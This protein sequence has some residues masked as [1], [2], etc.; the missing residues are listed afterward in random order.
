MS[1][2]QNPVIET[3]AADWR[4]FETTHRIRTYKV[5][6]DSLET[7]W[8]D[9]RISNYHFL[10]LRDNCPCSQ[11]VHPRTR[12]QLFEVL[13]APANLSAQRISLDKEGKLIVG[14]S[15]G[16]NSQYEAGW[17]RSHAYDPASRSERAERLRSVEPWGSELVIPS[18]DYSEVVSSDSVLLDW[19]LAARDVGL[20]MLTGVPSANEAVET[21]AKRISFMRET[22][23]GSIFEVKTKAETTDSNAYTSLELPAHTDM[24]TRELQPGLQF[25]HC[26]INDAAGGESTFVDGFAIAAALQAEAPED[27]RVLCEHPID[28]WNKAPQSDYRSHAPIIGLDARGELSEIRLTN[29]LRAPINLPSSEMGAFY[30]AY[31]H[32]S[33]LTRDS[34]FLVSHRLEAGQMWCFDNRRIMHGR[35][36]FDPTSGQ[37]F[38]R[39]GYMD[40][41][42][43]LSRIRVLERSH[44]RSTPMAAS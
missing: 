3:F 24:S 30:R 22:N 18:F 6:S 8:D 12:E 1:E 20:T 19:L 33:A 43:L 42:E 10:W 5:L 28:F 41:D 35:K 21:A 37:R 11:C 34:R 27:F 17:L 4:T 39:G 7:T 26:L 32:F 40:R 14:W 44:V 9:E 29:W 16:H 13:D 23:F 25:L 15:D 38:L 2:N 36:A 31:Q